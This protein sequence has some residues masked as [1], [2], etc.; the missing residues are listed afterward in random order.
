V[1]PSGVL[2]ALSVLLGPG[3]DQETPLQAA[4][5]LSGE[6]SPAAALEAARRSESPL[7]R[8]Q[9]ELYVLHRAGALDEALDAGLRALEVAPS[10]AWTLEETAY[11]ALSLGEGALASRLLERL[12][13]QLDPA[14]VG[15][16]AWMGEEA[17]RL[18]ARLEEEQRA[19][20][21]GRSVA[22]AGAALALVVALLASRTPGTPGA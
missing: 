8:A 14:G 7:E 22:A 10:D 11:V 9:A 16:T 5:R 1:N 3:P 12:A 2:L 18:A 6:G 4:V 21:L 17:G 15:R 19:L 20:R 13:P